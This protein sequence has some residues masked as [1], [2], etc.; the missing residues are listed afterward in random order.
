MLADLGSDV[1]SSPWRTVQRSWLPELAM[2]RLRTKERA[3][4][5]LARAE[6]KRTTT[7]VSL[8]SSRG[9]SESRCLNTP[10]ARLIARGGEGSLLDEVEHCWLRKRSS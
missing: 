9:R 8:R 2:R 6:S 10:A 3:G 7:H 4:D 1:R 5:A